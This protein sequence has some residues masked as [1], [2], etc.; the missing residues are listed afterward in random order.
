M[1][2][3]IIKKPYTKYSVEF[4]TEALK[5]AQQVGI[6]T[7]AKQLGLHESQLYDWRTK[8]QYQSNKSDIESQLMAEN[9]KLKRLL[10][11]R[12]EENAILKKAAVYF[13][14]NQK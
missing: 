1:K 7:A 8:A 4:K 3:N 9:A 14:K 13:A 6:S 12:D 10:A 5:L 11:E 2:K